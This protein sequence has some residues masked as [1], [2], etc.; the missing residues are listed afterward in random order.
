MTYTRPQSAGTDETCPV[1]GSV[2]CPVVC[3]MP[4]IGPLIVIDPKILGTVRL[5]SPC[6][7]CKFRSPSGPVLVIEAAAE[8]DFCVWTEPP[9]PR[10]LIDCTTEASTLPLLS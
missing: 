1:I 2:R 8:N 4:V 9:S 7:S 3:A 6:G 5:L 10:R